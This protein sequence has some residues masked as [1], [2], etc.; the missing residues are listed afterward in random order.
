MNTVEIYQVDTFTNQ[1]FKG[2]PAAVCVLEYPLDDRMYLNIANEMN[3]S[4]TA[5]VLPEKGN[6]LSD[7]ETFGLRWFTPKTEVPMCGHA[8]LAT[9]W[10]LFTEYNYQGQIVFK[11][12]GGVLKSELTTKGVKM[13]F[14]QDSPEKINVSSALI[15]SV[16]YRKKYNVF[17]GN[18]TG[19]LLIQLESE[20]DVRKLNPDFNLLENFSFNKNLRGLIVTS[21]GINEIDFVSRFFDPW[22][23]INEDPVTGSAHTVLGPFWS[24]ILRKKEMTAR[25][26]SQRTGELF[27]SL[28]DEK[29]VYITGNAVTIF[30]AKLHI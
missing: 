25:Q 6:D 27:I 3:L 19:Y 7:S 5:F 2:N 12:K 15:K 4:E 21:A 16:N 13:D 17:Y 29:R 1:P 30:K 10:V 26:L 28:P 20:E 11:T 18:R 8:T 14:P 22:E 9:S 23:G 24:K